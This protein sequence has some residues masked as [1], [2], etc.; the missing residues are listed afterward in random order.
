MKKT[1]AILLAAVMVLALAAC[2]KNDKQPDTGMPNPMREVSADEME[3]NVNVPKGAEDVKYFIIED[4]DSKMDQ[5]SY[6]LDGKDYCYRMQQTNE[7]ASYDM[8][9]IY[10]DKWETENTKVSGCDAVVMTSS[11]GSVI[12]WLDVV[13]GINYTLS[14]S[15]LLSASEL[16]EAAA[17]L[18]APMQGEA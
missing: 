16:S 14:C 7:V 13:P 12:Y 5:V 17:A 10:A 9:G 4:G 15:Q 8:S 2:A 3:F 11:E 1:I 18:F 6:T